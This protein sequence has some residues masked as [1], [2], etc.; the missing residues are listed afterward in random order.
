VRDVLSG[1]DSAFEC[2]KFRKSQ[3]SRATFK[4]KATNPFTAAKAAAVQ[5][6][7]AS[8]KITKKCN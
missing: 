1:K 5:R 4:A 3:A 8:T 7:K 2:T 6:Y